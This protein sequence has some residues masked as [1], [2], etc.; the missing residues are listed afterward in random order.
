MFTDQIYAHTNEC[1]SASPGDVIS[2]QPPG[3]GACGSRPRCKGL[4]CTKTAAPRGG[5]S[6][7]VVLTAP[8]PQSAKAQRIAHLAKLK[9]SFDPD[10]LTKLDKHALAHLLATAQYI[11]PNCEIVLAQLETIKDEF[12]APW[13][14]SNL[15]RLRGKP[16]G[17]TKP[18]GKR[19]QKIDQ[20]PALVPNL[21]RDFDV[22]L[23]LAPSVTKPVKTSKSGQAVVTADPMTVAIDGGVER[24]VNTELGE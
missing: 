20:D 23:P 8:R 10:E 12:W 1:S 15:G 19:T 16:S 17:K 5:R 2:N 7:I 24:K 13:A 9:Q 22:P 4:R 18:R 21:F 14:E 3:S 6:S 11:D